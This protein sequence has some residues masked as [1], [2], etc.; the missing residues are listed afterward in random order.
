[1]HVNVAEEEM[2]GLCACGNAEN[3]KERK[4]LYK[5]IQ[6]SSFPQAL[7][8]FCETFFVQRRNK[9]SKWAGWWLL[10]VEEALLAMKEVRGPRR[11]EQMK[12]EWD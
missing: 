8:L 1:M 3:K 5:C 4:G 11:K 6:P 10:E 12:C 7:L 2:G 9:K